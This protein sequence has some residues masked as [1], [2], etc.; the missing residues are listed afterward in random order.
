VV[1]KVRCGLGS[2]EVLHEGDAAAFAGEGDWLLRR[3][4][5]S[6]AAAPRGRLAT[7]SE[8]PWVLGSHHHSHRNVPAQSRGQRCGRRGV[9]VAL[10][11][12]LARAC[13]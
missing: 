6:K 10:S 8:R 4:A 13:T 11:V 3:A 1:G 2:A 7:R 12:E 9:V 5:P